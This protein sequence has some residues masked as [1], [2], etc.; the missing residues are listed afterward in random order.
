LA[1]GTLA[2]TAEDLKEVF[3]PV[4][5][6]VLILLSEQIEAVGNLLDSERIPILLVGGFGSNKYL[7]LRIMQQFENCM[8]LQPPDA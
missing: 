7:K 6:M 3:D 4:V 5:N 1:N 2:V 8:V